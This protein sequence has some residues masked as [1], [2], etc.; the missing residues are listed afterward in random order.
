MRNE[1][2]FVPHFLDHYRAMGVVHFII[3]DD[4]SSDGTREFLMSQDDCLVIT[5]DHHF[6]EKMPDG[7]PFHYHA[8]TEIAERFCPGEWYLCV[9]AD[10]FLF[11]P[12]KFP[13]LAIAVQELESQ[14]EVCAIAAMI[15]VYPRSLAGRNWMPASGPLE[16]REWWFD[17]EA[18]FT[19]NPYTGD[20]KAAARGVRVRLLDMLAK[21]RPEIVQAIYP[22]GQIVSKLWKVPLR[23]AGLGIVQKNTHSL[24]ITPPM[25]VQLGLV[26]FKFY[27]GLDQKIEEATRLGN[28]ARASQEYRFL[29]AAVKHLK[30]K[31]LVSDESV[32]F[33]GGRSLEEAGLIFAHPARWRPAPT[34]VDKIFGVPLVYERLPEVDARDDLERAILHEYE[35]ALAAGHRADTAWQVNLA[36]KRFHSRLLQ[37][38]VTT[39]T[40]LAGARTSA[41]DRNA[42]TA[43]KWSVAAQ[44]VVIPPGGTAVQLTSNALWSGIY[45]L[46]VDAGSEGRVSLLDTRREHASFLHRNWHLG[47]PKTIGELTTPAAMGLV[48]LFPSFCSPSLAAWKGTGLRVIVFLELTPTPQN[49]G[50][51]FHAG[52]QILGTAS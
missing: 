37:Q 12:A 3:Y 20:I 16:Q 41:V 34:R 1:I 29:A 30:D 52:R 26:H 42:G 17:R 48:L 44:A 43:P 47:D 18:G 38:L 51:V 33:A 4:N 35:Q 14:E 19:R 5:S 7:R 49:V 23:K 39:A 50:G 40:R 10:E 27:P 24:T 2:Y 11:L 6:Q 31:V 8:R 36:D 15:D 28:Y 21:E 45:H 46:R 25:N 22:E 32:A 9:D 13:S